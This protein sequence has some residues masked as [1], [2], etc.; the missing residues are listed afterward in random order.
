MKPLALLLGALAVGACGGAPSPAAAPSLEATA[1][2]EPEPTTIE[3]AES[4]VQRATAQLDSAGNAAPSAEATTAAGAR[5][6]SRTE[7]EECRALRSLERATTAL[8]RLAGQQDA[9]CTNATQA[10][11]RSRARVHCP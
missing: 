8:C 5:E 9:R 4:Q 7:R 2:Q 10:L 3:E 6:Y 1:P 11:E